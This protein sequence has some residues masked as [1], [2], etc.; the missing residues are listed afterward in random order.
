MKN[1]TL[2]LL[3]VG[4]VNG[5]LAGVEAFEVGPE[6]TGQLPRGKEADGILGDFIL[7]NGLVT[8]V[9]SGNQPLR[10]PNMSTF[11]G[12]GG[13]TPGCLYD[14]SM[15]A[16]PDDQ[17]T[18]FSPGRQRGAVSHVRISHA[19][20]E[21]AD[22]FAEVETVVDAARDKGLYK[23]HAYR[24][25][26]RARGVVVT[27]TFR[28]DSKSSRKVSADDYWKPSGKSGK[29]NDV[30]WIDSVDPADH[31]GYAMGWLKA[32]GPGAGLVRGSTNL[33]VPPGESR[34]FTRFVAV[35]SSPAEA[36][37]N[38]VA[39]AGHGAPVLGVRLQGQAR[40][41]SVD[42]AR[43]SIGSGEQSI[44]AY[45][46]S[47]G[48]L[49]V[50]LPEG[51][52]SVGISDLGR[53]SVQRKVKLTG[54]DRVDLDVA[55]SPRSGVKFDID[56]AARADI[57]CKVQFAGVGGTKTPNLGP[58]NRA[59]GCVDQWH[60]ETGE[61]E[62]ALDPGTY[63]LVVTRGIEH[64]HLVREVTVEAGRYTPVK[65]ILKRLVDTRGWVSTDFHNHS[66][67]SGD[68]QCGT[69]DRIINLAAEHIE[70][71]PTTEHNRLYDWTPHIQKLGL[72]EHLRTI[73]GLELTG[74]G[75]GS[76]HN[77][78][79]LPTPDPFAQDGGAP[80]FQTDPR[81]NV[82]ALQNLG[83]WNPS[84]WV[85][86]N[87]PNLGEKFWDRNLDGKADGG[88]IGYGD[89]ID[90][91]E[92]QNFRGN[93][94]L[95]TAPWKITRVGPRKSVREVRE[96]IWLQMLNQ[97]L[98]TRAIAVA[99]AHSVYGNGVGGWRTYVPS[100]T[101]AP[102]KID[103]S[104]IVRNAKDGRL[105]LT[106]GPYLEVTA[107]GVRAGSEIPAS[108]GKVKLKVKVQ[109]TDWVDINRV[110]VLVNGRQAP[111][112]NF[113]RKSHP[114]F[115]GEGIVKFERDIEVR[116][117]GDAHLVVVA[118]GEGQDLRTGYGTSTNARLQPCAYINPIW[119]DVDGKGFQPN[120][121]TLDWPLPVGKPSADKLESMLEARKAS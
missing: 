12:S 106:T 100:S 16:R 9:V 25:Y 103:P 72:S 107:N 44:L 77:A 38:V 47:E 56:G 116:L 65:G 60:S 58:Q 71:A 33:T 63:R 13:I 6:Q 74:S 35:G 61:F 87:H 15:N 96:F 53:E 109:C 24:L 95:A 22:A 57:P 64:G 120:G 91:I 98:R 40:D 62:V 101:D 94:S 36:Y 83:G 70:F 66:T 80:V 113:T 112:Y 89:L 11:Y 29:F 42:S 3:F 31:Y 110:Q 86:I 52:Y 119:V 23:R 115:F 67:P 48:E 37:G 1:L 75:A 51:E 97:G 59:H 76:H 20:G 17:L 102:G 4:L 2:L 28:N 10:R 68:N 92:S 18:I 8:A 73:I 26:A 5:C 21:G 43:V 39:F 78:F 88:F 117:A 82:I 114:D 41:S 14:L 111:E 85:H 99:D 104:E 27:T 105:M 81:L 32:D 50:R 30:R 69:D 45:V 7:R 121:D 90:A 93:D 19:G 54:A 108:S 34:L 55:L 84:R 79:P 46:G 49:A 118:M